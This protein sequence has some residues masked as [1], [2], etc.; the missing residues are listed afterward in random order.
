MTSCEK[1]QLV[2]AS[3]AFCS[4]SVPYRMPLLLIVT[5]LLNILSFIVKNCLCITPCKR[6]KVFL[7]VGHSLIF[8]GM[9][10]WYFQSRTL[11][12]AM[13]LSGLKLLIVGFVSGLN[14]SAVTPYA[15]FS[16]QLKSPGPL[17]I[18]VSTYRHP[19][20]E[21]VGFR[22]PVFAF[23]VQFSSVILILHQIKTKVG[24][25]HFIL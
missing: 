19:A 21:A 5:P 9:T 12:F 11:I 20:M 8:H 2:F 6:V 22:G 25:M 18:F 23:S 14:Q 7:M 1:T 16:K 24:S 10:Q 4:V 15:S 13:Q 17:H 3:L